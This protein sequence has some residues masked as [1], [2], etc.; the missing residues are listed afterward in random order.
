MTRKE[1]IA[2]LSAFF[3]IDELVCPHTYKRWGE[4][5][6]QF[7][8]TRY[9]HC[10]L[11]IR[12][13]ILRAPMYANGGTYTQRGLRCNLCAEVKSKTNSNALYLSQ[14]S[15][16]KAGD[17]VSPKM[18]AERMRTEI[19]RQGDLLPYPIRLEQGVTWLHFDVMEQYGVESK[20]YLFKA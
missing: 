8:D 1:I 16:G 3:D 4:K 15:F 17:F 19:V 14:H 20:V 7:L 12:R 2:Q 18:T 6:W 5:S 13:D 9:L 11:V 10:L